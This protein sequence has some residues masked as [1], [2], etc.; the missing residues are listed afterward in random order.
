MKIEKVTAVYFSPNGSTRK[1]V[2]ELAQTMGYEH[3]EELDL[4]MVEAR[5]NRREFGKEE[6]VIIGF[7]VYADRI[8]SLSTEIFKL[9]QGEDTPGVAVVTYGNRAYGDA[10]LELKN[11]M[12]A[13]GMRVISGAAIIGEHC[14]NTKIGTQRPDETDHQ[15]IRSYAKLISK[16]LEELLGI[17]KVK[18]IEIP[19]N[20]PYR[21]FGPH[22]VPEGDEKCIQC[23]ICFNHCPVDAISP[24]NYKMTDADL[25]I[26]C[27]RCIQVCPT[28]A[29]DIKAQSFLSFMEKLEVKCKEPKAMEIFI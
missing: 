8:P 14:L 19:G 24:E 12:E 1:A 4:T 28:K 2:M 26:F 15:E 11:E 18:E 25:C 13:V 10:L 21:P 5:Q 22:H 29:R 16:K 27:G 23:G 9:L 20:F 6:L 7:P 3:V 17:D